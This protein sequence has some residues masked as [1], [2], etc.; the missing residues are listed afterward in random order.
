MFVGGLQY[1]GAVTGVFRLDGRFPGDTAAQ[2]LAEQIAYPLDAG[3]GVDIAYR[4]DCMAP[5]WV[6]MLDLDT[7]QIT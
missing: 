6:V 7:S 5:A 1:Q 4:A 2:R 3:G